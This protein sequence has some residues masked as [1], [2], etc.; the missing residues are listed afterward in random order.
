DCRCRTLRGELRE[1][2]EMEDVVEETCEKEDRA[3]ADDAGELAGPVDLAGREPDA[4]GGEDARDEPAAAEQRSRARV[5]PVR[6]WRGDDVARSGCV[7]EPPD[8]QEA[9]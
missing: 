8:R 2:R 5:P 6:P 1:R 9:R 7:E 3:A 4:D